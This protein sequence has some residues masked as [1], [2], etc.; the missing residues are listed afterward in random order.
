MAT[1][2]KILGQMTNWRNEMA[3]TLNGNRT[4]RAAWQERQELLQELEDCRRKAIADAKLDFGD[5]LRD[6]Q[7]A[8]PD[9]ETWYDNNDNIPLIL[10]WHDRKQIDDVIARMNARAAHVATVTQTGAAR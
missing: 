5:A 7:A 4:G 2:R 9:W 1:L 8:D 10:R 3:L 6:L